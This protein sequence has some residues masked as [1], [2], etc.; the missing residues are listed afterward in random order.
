M[1]Q[2]NENEV[3]SQ[4]MSMLCVLLQGRFPGIIPKEIL[5][6]LHQYY[7]PDTKKQVVPEQLMTIAEVAQI[8]KL[9]PRQIMNILNA[10]NGLTRIRIGNTR[11]VRIAASDLADFINRN[12]QGGC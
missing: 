6:A 1:K 11:S 4:A 8:L 12:Q 2:N 5:E 10:E 3:L 9:S 7:F